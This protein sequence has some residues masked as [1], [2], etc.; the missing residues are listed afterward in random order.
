M[1]EPYPERFTLVTAPL[2]RT[3]VHVYPRNYD[4]GAAAI[5]SYE[6]GG[7]TVEYVNGEPGNPLKPGYLKMT[8]PESTHTWSPELAEIHTRLGEAWSYARPSFLGAISKRWHRLH[9]DFFHWYFA[10]IPAIRASDAGIHSTI[11]PEEW[12]TLLAARLRSMRS[13]Q[14]R[15]IR[16]ALARIADV[17]ESRGRP[18]EA[19]P[20]RETKTLCDGCRPRTPEMEQ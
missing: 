15:S 14:P 7:Y 8:P 16:L 17:V 10:A 9:S 2:P 11:M 4:D 13:G 3:P 18:Y 19:C 12:V 1:A 6:A 20:C 5:K